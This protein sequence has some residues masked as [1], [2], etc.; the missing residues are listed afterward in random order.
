MGNRLVPEIVDSICGVLKMQIERRIEAPERIQVAL[1]PQYALLDMART[2][3]AIDKNL[4][5]GFIY[6]QVEQFPKAAYEPLVD[7]ESAGP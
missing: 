4:R 6:L 3:A 5:I 7:G 1:Q 2:A